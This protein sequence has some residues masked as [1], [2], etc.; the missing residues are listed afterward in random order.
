MYG[1]NPLLKCGIRA[2]S[3]SPFTLTVN[4]R[5]NH[6]FV[7]TIHEVQS[8]PLAFTFKTHPIHKQQLCVYVDKLCV[9]SGWRGPCVLPSA[10]GMKVFRIG[11]EFFGNATCNYRR[12]PNEVGDTRAYLDMAKFKAGQVVQ[13]FGYKVRRSHPFTLQLKRPVTKAMLGFGTQPK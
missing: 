12:E 2:T 10:L 5:L 4:A 11:N 1:Y 13:G 3:N 9:N 8:I 7:G 6:D